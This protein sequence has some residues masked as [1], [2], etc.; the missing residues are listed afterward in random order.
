MILPGRRI[1]SEL[2]T[3]VHGSAV[4]AR[5]MFSYPMQ[6]WE[7]FSNGSG[8]S[9]GNQVL[10]PGA[11]ELPESLA[12]LPIA[13]PHAPRPVRHL[14]EKSVPLSVGRVRSLSF[15][16]PRGG[17][18]LYNINAVTLSLQA[19][20]VYCIRGLMLSSHRNRARRMAGPVGS[21]AYS[22]GLSSS[23]NTS[24]GATS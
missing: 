6:F 22:W 1:R 7:G 10:S 23:E 4:H 24:S 16:A 5:F 18:A 9:G 12:G 15:A 3:S 17:L 19:I 14:V 8:L 2:K 20:A 21:D 11:P 13:L